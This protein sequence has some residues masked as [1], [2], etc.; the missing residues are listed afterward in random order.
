[1]RFL[2]QTAFEE[3][4]QELYTDSMMKHAWLHRDSSEGTQPSVDIFLNKPVAN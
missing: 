3:N 2:G 4:G 1:M